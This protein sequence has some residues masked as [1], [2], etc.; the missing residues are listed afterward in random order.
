MQILVPD[1]FVSSDNKCTD[2]NVSSDNECAD[3][4]S[5]LNGLGEPVN[6]LASMFLVKKQ[7][8]TKNKKRF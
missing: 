2:W 8:K 6:G 5:L 7:N 1:I 4:I 3:K